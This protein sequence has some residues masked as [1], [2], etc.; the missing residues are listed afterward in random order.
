MKMVLPLICTASLFFRRAELWW[1]DTVAALFSQASFVVSC[2]QPRQGFS[3]QVGLM[4]LRLI[5]S[6]GQGRDKSRPRLTD[7]AAEEAISSC[8]RVS[9]SICDP[10]P[11]CLSFSQLDDCHFRTIRSS[12][13]G[14]AH[15]RR[16]AVSC[17]Q[18][19]LSPLLAAL[20][21]SRYKY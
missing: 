16:A 19:P 15:C 8:S 12:N 4:M 1:S 13:E 11:T 3:K 6:V 20:P 7:H 17:C 5:V 18:F 14:R 21:R 9:L 2:S 10:R